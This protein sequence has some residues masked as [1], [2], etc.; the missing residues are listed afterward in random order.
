MKTPSS[1]TVILVHALALA[2]CLVVPRVAAQSD[3]G[4]SITGAVG[5][6]YTVQYNTDL[7]QA[8]DAENTKIDGLSSLCV[9]CVL[10]G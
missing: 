7:A 4:L 10:C 2:L 6:V 3:V 1:R 5:K 8:D 9:L